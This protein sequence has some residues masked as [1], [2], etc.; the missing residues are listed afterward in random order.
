CGRSTAAATCR[1]TS[2]S[3][4][5]CAMW[6]TGRSCST[7]R[8]CGRPG[9]RYPAGLAHTEQARAD[10]MECALTTSDDALA[11]DLAVAAGERLLALRAGGGDAGSLRRAGD[12]QSHEFL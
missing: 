10:R 8:S 9:R 5:T 3:A 4:W 12:R 7:S 11:R 1:G 2:R 6:K